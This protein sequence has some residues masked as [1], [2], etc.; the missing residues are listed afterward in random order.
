MLSVRFDGSLNEIVTQMRE[1][2]GLVT[3]DPRAQPQSVTPA[4]QATPK[5]VETKKVEKLAEPEPTAPSSHVVP[6][7]DDV[8]AMSVRLAKAKGRQTV[9]DLLK[10]F[11]AQSG[12]D[13]KEADRATYIA[14]AQAMIPA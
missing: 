12:A 11:G 13:V 1:F 14:K 3:V 10:E 6:S 4:E 7:L 9:V 2:I 8:K 5:P